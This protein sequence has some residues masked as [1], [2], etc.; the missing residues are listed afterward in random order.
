[1]TPR[2]LVKAAIQHRETPR[3]PY[4]ILLTGEAV[5]NIRK[6]LGVEDAMAWLDNDVQPIGVPWWGWHELGG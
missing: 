1:M 4:D 3:V 6:T 5:E 2:E